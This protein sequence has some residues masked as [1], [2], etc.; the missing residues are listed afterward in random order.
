MKILIA[1]YSATGNTRKLAGVLADELMALGHEVDLADMLCDEARLEDYDRVGLAFPVMIFRVPN[2]VVDFIQ[3]LPRQKS[4]KT[5]FALITSGGG[6][7]RTDAILLELLVK[8]N[9]SL[10]H[11]KEIVCGDSYIPFRKW[12][13]AFQKRGHPDE[14]DEKAARGFAKQAAGESEGRWKPKSGLDRWFFHLFIARTAPL[15]AG[16]SFLG[17][18]RL[19]RNLCNGC[20]LCARVCPAEAV[21]L[22]EG[23]SVTDTEKCIGCCACF[24]NCPEAALLLERFGPEYYYKGFKPVSVTKPPS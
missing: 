18:R 4:E 19:D 2:P 7:A 6:P 10:A 17:K 15:N 8:K 9:I 3:R 13:K 12:L 20:G 21:T 11:C 22:T 23:K 16:R 1:W 5:A 24:N 14:S